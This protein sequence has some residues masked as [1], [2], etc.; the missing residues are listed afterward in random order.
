[1]KYK[2]L[3]LAA[4][5]FWYIFYKSGE[6]GGGHVPCPLDLLLFLLYLIKSEKSKIKD[7]QVQL[8]WFLFWG[9]DLYLFRKLIRSGYKN[10]LFVGS[11]LK[12]AI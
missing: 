11:E 1:M 8:E 9:R 3:P 4:I 7:I 6:G 12:L 2:L 10:C 5:F